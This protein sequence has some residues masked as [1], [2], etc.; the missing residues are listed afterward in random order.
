MIPL[1][2]KNERYNVGN[3][4]SI[5]I[6]SCISKIIERLMH[7][8]LSSFLLRYNILYQC[9]YGFREGYSTNLALVE[10]MDQVH[11]VLNDG[12]YVLGLYLN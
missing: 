7:K 8:R 10:I 5:A 12:N 1:Y 11:K 6:L 4:R 2:K 3:Y 9:Q